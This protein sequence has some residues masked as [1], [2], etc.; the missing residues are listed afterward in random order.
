MSRLMAE[1]MPLVIVPRSFMPSGL[2]MATTLSPT[3]R[4]SESPNSA[5]VRP[6]ASIFKTARSVSSSLP[7]S[8]ASYWLSSERTIM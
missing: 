6:V 2:P 1:T 3:S 8:A 4:L 7:T 5:A